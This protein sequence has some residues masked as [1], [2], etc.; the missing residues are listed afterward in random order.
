[1]YPGLSESGG[2]GFSLALL[3]CVFSALVAEMPL[4]DHRAR[5]G[6]GMG[7]REG[8]S[9]TQRE[10]ADWNGTDRWCVPWG[11]GFPDTGLAADPVP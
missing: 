7:R 8:V 5:A 10:R 6:G 11:T 3:G 4:A 1:M 9:G 2:P